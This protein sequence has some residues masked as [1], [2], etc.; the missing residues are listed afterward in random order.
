MSEM[1]EDK[2]KYVN[3]MFNRYILKKEIIAHIIN[4]NRP[5]GNHISSRS[6]VIDDNIIKQLSMSSYNDDIKSII[7]DL[8]KKL[9]EVTKEKKAIEEELRKCQQSLGNEINNKANDKKNN[10]ETIENLQRVITEK[11][12]EIRN[13]GLEIQKKNQLINEK[14]EAIKAYNSKIEDLMNAPMILNSMK[15]KNS[16]DVDELERTL[17]NANEAFQREKEN[18]KLAIEEIKS[19]KDAIIKNL[20]NII[21]DNKNTLTKAKNE[22]IKI[23]KQLSEERLKLKGKDIQINELKQKIKEE[24]DNKLFEKDSIIARKESKIDSIEKELLNMK[25]SLSDKDTILTK[26]E[27]AIEEQNKYYKQLLDNLEKKLTEKN[28]T[29][30]DTKKYYE[31]NIYDLEKNQLSI[32]EKNKEIE[33]NNTLLNQK[34]LDAEKKISEQKQSIIQKD[35]QINEK[36]QLFEKTTTELK[37]EISKKINIITQK[38]QLIKEK[39]L[40]IAKKENTINEN[41]NSYQ[42]LNEENQKKIKEKEN[43][44]NNQI[45]T[46]KEKEYIISNQVKTIQE[47]ESK[48]TNLNG[49]IDKCSQDITL[50]KKQNNELQSTITNKNNMI[51]SLN[52]SIEELNKK[53]KQ[54]QNELTEKTTLINNINNHVNLTKSE[55]DNKVKDSISYSILN[56]NSNTKEINSY[57]KLSD[58]IKTLIQKDNNNLGQPLSKSILLDNNSIINSIVEIQQNQENEY[59]NILNNTLKDIYNKL[60][61]IQKIKKKSIK[62]SSSSLLTIS[63]YIYISDNREHE[64]LYL[65]MSTISDLLSSGWSFTDKLNSTYSKNNIVISFIGNSSS[66]KTTMLNYLFNTNIKSIPTN[67]I[68]FVYFPNI[69]NILLIDTPG[70]NQCVNSFNMK[71]AECNEIKR[72]N[73]IIETIALNT[74]TFICYVTNNYTYKEQ[75]EINKLKRRLCMND[76]DE[77]KNT[78]IRTL[79][80]IHNKPKITTKKEYDEYISKNIMTDKKR[81]KMVNN[82]I[83]EIITNEE[84]AKNKDIIHFVISQYNAN[85]IKNVIHTKI[86]AA[87]QIKSMSIQSMLQKTFEEIGNSMFKSKKVS[88]SNNKVKIL[89]GVIDDN[90][91]DDESYW[92]W[93]DNLTPH[94]SYLINKNGNLELRVEM[95]C[96]NG[97]SIKAEIAND[98]NVFSIKGTKKQEEDITVSNRQYGTYLLYLKVP[99]SFCIIKSTKFETKT[100]INGLLTVEYAIYQKYSQNEE[101]DE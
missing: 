68:K 60:E 39:E 22:K 75:K 6:E 87:I 74:S 76:N 59:Q 45:K 8:N 32:S 30:E 91:Y 64:I 81:F 15:N 5:K 43:I 37:L 36:T 48:I 62:P 89:E 63:P 90:Y 16:T 12:S 18:L 25:R 67:D 42:R 86:K 21:E 17:K 29:I 95:N 54:T 26:K 49:I 97:M 1:L 46:I 93:M 100:Y 27:G 23:E 83:Q 70:L 53:L 82:I 72:K 38:E 14:E 51:N 4:T 84:I 78:G 33:N 19:E 80:V 7:E 69:P 98:K 10:K 66:G 35:N 52:N 11:E 94:Y 96:M 20:Q 61:D 13:L 34:L 57:K 28:K 3:S 85:E 41:R 65:Q 79:I 9:I 77:S 40:I 31:K 44:I 73:N 55:T 24:Y 99:T 47:K 2:L 88:I 101:D 71:K 50:L 58:F 92:L 56:V